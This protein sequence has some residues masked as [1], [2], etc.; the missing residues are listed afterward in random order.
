MSA[1]ALKFCMPSPVLNQQ[2]YTSNLA[3]MVKM[4]ICFFEKLSDKLIAT[5][6]V[7]LPVTGLFYALKLKNKRKTTYIPNHSG[8]HDISKR[9]IDSLVIQEENL[10][11]K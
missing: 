8:K 6:P 2:S 9:L 7:I 11:F 1:L 10:T 5:R 4:Q 3:V